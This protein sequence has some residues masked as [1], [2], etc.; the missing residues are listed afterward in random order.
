MLALSRPSLDGC[1]YG[2]DI[3]LHHGCQQGD[4]PRASSNVYPTQLPVCLH[5]VP[6]LL[7]LHST[8]RN[9]DD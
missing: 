4:K 9:G 6:E 1:C 5:Q 3:W 7:V 2:G 8:D